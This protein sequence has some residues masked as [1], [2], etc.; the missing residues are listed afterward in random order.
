MFVC[1]N[2][3]TLSNGTMCVRERYCSF[4]RTIRMKKEMGQHFCF[5]QRNSFFNHISWSYFKV[6]KLKMT[7]MKH[8]NSP[9]ESRS[10]KSQKISEKSG[11]SE[12]FGTIHAREHLNNISGEKMK[13]RDSLKPK[14]AKKKTLRLS[15]AAWDSV[16]FNFTCDLDMNNELEGMFPEDHEDV[17]YSQKDAEFASDCGS[18]SSN[19]LESVIG[20]DN[21]LQLQTLFE[22]TLGM[23]SSDRSS[24]SSQ[25][26]SASVLSVDDFSCDYSSVF[27]N[28]SD[29]VNINMNNEGLTSCEDAA[30]SPLTPS[31]DFDDAW[32]ASP[33]CAMSV[34][35]TDDTLGTS[36]QLSNDEPVSLRASVFPKFV[37]ERKVFRKHRKVAAA[38]FS[39][40]RKIG[41]NSFIGSEELV[42]D[43]KRRKASDF[44]RNILMDWLAAHQGE[45]THAFNHSI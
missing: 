34:C 45:R 17:S 36:Q 3:K 6:K 2:K 35:D 4:N 21:V 22:D 18:S 32:C 30:M 26:S 39:P 19:D 7:V 24:C 8:A 10:F 13:K 31:C 44:S 38:V 27:D 20:E 28:D 43:V 1:S 37:A 42:N 23:W 40:V 16:D 15:A 12:D 11:K 14:V 5:W 29:C 9:N 41:T 25:S 33:V